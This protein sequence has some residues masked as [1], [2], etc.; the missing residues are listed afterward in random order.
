MFRDVPAARK[1]LEGYRKLTP[2]G[3]RPLILEFQA[4]LAD[5]DKPKKGDKG[6]KKGGK[7]ST[8]KEGS[9][10]TAKPPTKKRKPPAPSSIAAPKRQKQ[11]TRK[12]KCPIPS[13][14]EGLD[15]ETESDIQIEEDQPIHSEEEE[16]VHT[17]E[18]QVRNEEPLV[19]NE[20]ETTNPKVTQTFN[21]SVPSP[22]PSP[23]TTTTPITIV[24]Y[25]PPVSSSQQ[26]SI[27]LSTP[28]FTDSTILSTTSAT[29]AVSVNLYDTG[30]KTS[31]FSTH[32]TSHIP[33]PN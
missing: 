33:Y 2:S 15:S 3:F 25:P 4:I 27:L 31:G 13:E 8:D 30:A 29:L 18:D 26:T 23:K 28:I 11:P 6:V 21:D 22:P 20:G 10:A 12:R 14:S 16:H 32:F 5:A 24:P 7:K 9:S 19:R 17:E 1:I